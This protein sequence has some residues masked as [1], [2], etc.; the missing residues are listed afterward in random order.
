[1]LRSFARVVLVVSLMS[2]TSA[3]AIGQS[4][5]F[6]LLELYSS[7]DRSEQFIVLEFSGPAATL[8]GQQITFLSGPA[9]DPQTRQ[10]V[11][12]FPS[13]GP[14]MNATN[15]RLL[16]ATQQFA[17]RHSLTPD[18]VLPGGMLFA[19]GG[20]IVLPTGSH[21][22]SDLP[23]DGNN[24]IYLER[25]MVCGSSSCFVIYGDHTGPAVA[26]NGSGA[27]S[28]LVP[29]PTVDNVEYYNSDLDDYFITS[30]PDEI[31]ALDSGKFSN[32]Q[33]TGQTLKTWVG[34]P[35]VY[36]VIPE[37]ASV[38][39]VYL[40]G[41][42]FYALYGYPRGAENDECY[43]MTTTYHLLG[44]ILETGAAF[45]ALFPDGAGN[46]SADQ[47]PVY[48]LWRPPAATHRYTTQP[49][50]RSE[51]LSRGWISEGLGPEGVAMCV[52]R[53]P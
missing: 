48:R 22:Y 49:V 20:I 41:A 15:G 19:P 52:P 18:F 46:C 2:L 14:N 6:Y 36:R 27:S 30:F 21:D 42:H 13:G 37:S 29:I 1:M 50:I 31:N 12:T 35:V 25:G 34:P 11:Y 43:T 17:D 4:L 28:N 10:N 3:A 47:V 5:Q 9:T 24:A 23:T 44:T 32:W 45:Y 26:I 7:A 33:R 8:A 51:M 16:L 39:R 38:C 53:N 40:D